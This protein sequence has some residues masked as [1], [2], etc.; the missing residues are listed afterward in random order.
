MKLDLKAAR[1]AIATKIAEPLRLDV[2]EAAKGILRIAATAMSWAVKTVTTERGLDAASF[3]LIAYGGAGPLHAS[4]IAREIGMGRVIVPRAPGHFCAF[5]MLFS[6]LRYDYVRTW[7]G[8]LAILS[9]ADMG[10]VYDD[11]IAQGRAALERGG[12]GAL[13]ANIVRWA[14]MRYVGQEHAVTI[15][16][17]QTLLRKQ[18]RLGVKQRFDEEHLLRYGTC[19]PKEAAEI[20]SLRVTVSGV[21]KKPPLEEITRGTRNPVA[22]ASRGERPV[23]YDGRKSAIRTPVFARDA[24]R[25][26]NKII[27]PALIEEHASTTVV[28]PGDTVTVDKFG[29]LVIEIGNPAHI[30]RRNR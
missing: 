8:R 14:D 24:L 26:G 13:K 19:A 5:G 28:F 11:L 12:A 15:E 10:A 4:A 1:A 16:L 23:H 2:I 7:P 6:D 20:V 21:M 9:F 22:A 27:G 18:D 30:S 29:D 25:A 17:P 3:P